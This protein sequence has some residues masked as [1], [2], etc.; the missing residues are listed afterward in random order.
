[1]RLGTGK[2]LV[3]G[4]ID[5][6]GTVLQTAELFDG[7]TFTTITGT[8][9][10]MTAG[11]LLATATLLNNGRVLIAGGSGAT[12]SADLFDP[13]AGAFSTTAVPL[14]QARSQHTATLL[15]NGTVLLAGGIVSS[16]A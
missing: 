8:G 15:G 13:L 14:Q 7:G 5:A 4:G 12:A 1:T 2:V 6:L 11:R 10:T 9:S 3:A 16:S